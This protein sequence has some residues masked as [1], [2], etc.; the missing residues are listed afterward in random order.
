MANAASEY[1]CMEES[2]ETSDEPLSPAPMLTR[3]R[4]ITSCYEFDVLIGEGAYGY[5]WK[6]E[7]KKNKGRVVAIKRVTPIAK[8]NYINEVRILQR[9]NHSRICQLFEV[10]ENGG[11]LYLVLEYLDGGD[12]QVLLEKQELCE[13]AVRVIFNQVTSALQHAHARGISHRDLK[14]ENIVVCDHRLYQ[15]KLVDWGTSKEFLKAKMVSNI[16]SADYKAPEVHSSD[17][18][19]AYSSAC[20]MWSLGIT[21]YVACTRRL[22]FW[23]KLTKRVAKM[24]RE[25]YRLEGEEWQQFSDTLKDF[26]RNLLKGSPGDRMTASAALSHEFLQDCTDTHRCVSI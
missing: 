19:I 18:Q 24:L 21:V 8:D 25:E 9:L 20:D 12:L 23:G 13:P 14:P 3:K 10:F 6:A 17:H 5:V 16:G 2:L 1:A 7:D 22:A 4:D 11:Q 26:I 15:V